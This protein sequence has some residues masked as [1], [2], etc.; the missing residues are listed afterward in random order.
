[1]ENNSEKIIDNN[2]EKKFFYLTK[3]Q[4]GWVSTITNGLSV[5][6]QMYTLF[7]TF[8]AQSFSMAFIWLMTLLNFVYFLL[9]LLQ[10]NIGFALATFFFV[11]YN[12]C[13][14]YVHHCGIG[15]SNLNGWFH[16]KITKFCN[17]R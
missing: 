13:V 11:V 2:Q 16:S 7:K 12:L 14:V 3:A 15:G 8:K 1:M 10:N 17:P 9:A 5:V 6:V 4:W